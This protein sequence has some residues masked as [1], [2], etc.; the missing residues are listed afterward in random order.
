M[1]YSDQTIESVGYAE[2]IIEMENPLNLPL[3]DAS[4]TQA[5]SRFWAKWNVFSGRSSRS[6]FW[7][8]V[9]TICLINALLF[10]AL[11]RTSFFEVLT[12]LDG[13]TVAVSQATSSWHLVWTSIFVAFNLLLLIPHLAVTWRRLHD[14]N[15]SGSWFFISFVPLIGPTILFIL[16]LLPSNPA[17]ERFD[18]QM[19]R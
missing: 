9:G 8:V 5:W 4:F 17:G 12:T 15:L 11:S 19:I 1:S 7:W 18:E 14:S 6:E 16:L 13:Q 2:D 3:P 10:F